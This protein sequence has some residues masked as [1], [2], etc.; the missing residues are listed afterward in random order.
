MSN[1]NVKTKVC[2]V[3]GKE[4][5]VGEF[6]SRGGG[7]YRTTCRVC[8]V[9]NNN[10]LEE[11]DVWSLGEYHVVIDSLINKKVK[12]IN[13]I[14]PMLPNKTLKDIVI[15]LNKDIKLG[16]IPL[17]VI[18]QCD[19]CGG[20]IDQKL[21]KFLEDGLRFC[22]VKCSTDH[23]R[24]N[25]S[26]SHKP[27]DTPDWIDNIDEFITN[28]R[29]L[30]RKGAS[31]LYG[32]HT[33]TITYW[34]D[35]YN[36]TSSIVINSLSDFEVIHIFN[37]VLN[38]KL[39]SFP[40]GFSKHKQYKYIVLKH[41]FD[42]VLNWGYQ[43]ICN[44]FGNNILEEY[45]LDSIIKIKEAKQLIIEI[46]SEYNIKLWEF[47][48]HENF[49]LSFWKIDDNI[50]DALK[51]L[52]YKLN[53]DKNIINGSDLIDYN[54]NQLLCDYNLDSLCIV[55][56]NR[57]SEK[58]FSKIFNEDIKE[59]N[60]VILNKCLEC[61]E[62][63]EFTNEFFPKGNIHSLFYLQN[64]CLE[65]MQ[66]REN[67]ALYKDKGILYEEIT[68]IPLEKWWEYFYNGN[69]TQ[70]P[71]HCHIQENFIKIVRFIVFEKMSCRTKDEIC[72]N[73]NCP[74]LN[75]YKIQITQRF[76]TV[77]ETLQICFP[78]F[79]ILEE[80]V[81]KYDDK[82][83]I[84]IF[85]EWMK[86]ENITVKQILNSYGITGLFNKEMMNLWQSKRRHCNMAHMDL[87]IWLFGIK[88]TTHP[89]TRK[90]IVDLDFTN[91]TDGFWEEKDNRI[92]AIQHYCENQ[93]KESILNFLDSWKNVQEW[94]LKYFSKHKLKELYTFAT[95]KINTYDLLI[96][97]YPIIKNKNLLFEWELSRN[98]KT[99]LQELIT[100]LREFV[101]HRM[102]DL[103]FDIKND[104]PIYLNFTFMLE[105]YPKFCGYLQTNNNR[106]RK[107]SSFYEWACL[108]FPEYEQYWTPEDFGLCM[109]FDGTKCNSKQEIMVYE[110]A[111]RDMEIQEFCAIGS[112]HSGK[113]TF[114]YNGV[115]KMCPDFVIDCY[116][117]TDLAKPIIIEYYG[118]YIKDYQGDNTMFKKY[119][120]KIVLKNN[121]YKNNKDII[122]IDLYP[123]DLKNNCEGVKNKINNILSNI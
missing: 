74:N 53:S 76:N 73:V 43:D 84:K 114:K 19:N 34:A 49:P 108:S 79:N 48:K 87:L 102:N 110:T 52:K 18:R 50:N 10:K 105:L 81:Y 35:K 115:N 112:T 45:K 46:Y 5:P 17:K 31:L 47:K 2:K 11:N 121:Y 55:V 12:N 21:Y 27:K 96:D 111:K 65:C 13:E 6:H 9:I 117:N 66:K 62:T 57:N 97:A 15:F 42:S 33:K 16:N 64:I 14:E 113:Y 116:N 80:D 39:K 106:T 24:K 67:K 119:Q 40:N 94:T 83:A 71:K 118:L 51:W 75:Q 98:N 68:D 104:L 109:A 28:Y 23:N 44:Q 123:Y 36:I 78:E 69:I 120:E 56:F 32:K 7:Y 41:L 58:L 99:S 59:S 4:K 70:M 85:D 92:R 3:C 88:N 107:F 22:S 100:F 77:L 60:I 8:M 72:S 1:E 86:S 93:C 29:V 82:T 91:K 101:N 25:N 95:F 122:F 38:G 26:W 30:G 37:L 103:V 89:I 20:D 61:E 90:P 63:K 54:L